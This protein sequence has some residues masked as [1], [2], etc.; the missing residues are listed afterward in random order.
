MTEMANMLHAHCQS[1]TQASL[2]VFEVQITPIQLE[3]QQRVILSNSSWLH[4]NRHHVI[5]NL[6]YLS[7]SLVGHESKHNASF[8]KD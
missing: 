8:A 5:S 4:T 7:C 3:Q 1:I 2:F 6:A